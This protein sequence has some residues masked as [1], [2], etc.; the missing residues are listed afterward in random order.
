M[1]K[2]EI[3]GEEEFLFAI[4]AAMKTT[5]HSEALLDI[6]KEFEKYK[7]FMEENLESSSLVSDSVFLFR[8]EYQLKKNVWKEVE[9]Y[10]NQT[11]D[12]LAECIIE[13]MG[14]ENDHLSAFFFPEKRKDGVW[15]WY[16]LY[17]I[18]SEGVDND[19]FPILHTNDVLVSSIDYHKHPKIGF[20]F[21]FGDD[22]RF[23]MRYK[24]ERKAEKI[25]R[26][27]DFPKLIDQRGVPPEQYPEYD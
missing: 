13:S 4:G 10:G 14:W 23:F 17:E 18:G 6:V 27:G 12:M 3:Q 11:L 1:Y 16:T 24:G 25:E 21:D 22:H 9:I 8:F 2:P 15:H 20:V 19:Q 7:Q 26:E 5:T